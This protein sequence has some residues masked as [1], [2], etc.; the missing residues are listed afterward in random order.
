MASDASDTSAAGSPAPDG[1]NHKSTTN[2]NSSN[3]KSDSKKKR[4]DSNATADGNAAAK[5]TKRR[6]ARACVSCRARK[7]RCNVV[8]EWPCTNCRF[9]NVEVSDLPRLFEI[10]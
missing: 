8:E 9:D 6:A 7:V 2:N 3:G 5:V 1:S 10:Q 4:S